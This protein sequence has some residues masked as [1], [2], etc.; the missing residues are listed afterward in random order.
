M[1]PGRAR[2][3]TRARRNLPG[4]D[5]LRMAERPRPYHARY[6]QAARW[7]AAASLVGRSA[8]VCA[9]SV[10]EHSARLYRPSASAFIYG[11][12]ATSCQAL[13]LCVAI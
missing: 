7:K 3:G 6:R 5:V 10:V 2:L 8:A 1:H 13:D 4:T 11:A 9:A 12:T